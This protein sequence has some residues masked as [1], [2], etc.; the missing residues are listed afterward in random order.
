MTE[1][2]NFVG[3]TGAVYRD[4]GCER[5]DYHLGHKSKC[6]E[7]PFTEGCRRDGWEC[8]PERL[9]NSEVI[10]EDWCKDGNI[11]N[12]AARL[13]M[14]PGT[15]RAYL[16]DYESGGIA[17]YRDCLAPDHEQRRLVK[18]LIITGYEEGR[19]VKELAYGACISYQYACKILR[20]A[21]KR[22]RRGRPRKVRETCAE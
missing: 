4:N 2:N 15:V 11:R 5:A 21:G 18:Q 20:D 12:T 22:L 8:A 19:P 7:C 6:T 16:M 17:L 10:F 3:D 14:A 13:G 9:R 1:D